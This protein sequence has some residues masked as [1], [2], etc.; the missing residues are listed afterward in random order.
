MLISKNIK[1]N[2]IIYLIPELCSATG[3]NKKLMENNELIKH[4]FNITDL[5]SEKRA[6]QFLKLTDEIHNKRNSSQIL[7]NWKIELQKEMK[8]IEGRVMPREL[9]KFGNL[10]E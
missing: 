10:K 3:I 1:T 4:L 7:L 8:S 5:N 9:I 2:D 6:K